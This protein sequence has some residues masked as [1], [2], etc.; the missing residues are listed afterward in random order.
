MLI[1]LVCPEGKNCNEDESYNNQGYYRKYSIMG[2]GI[3]RQYSGRFQCDEKCYYTG[4]N[5]KSALT[6][7]DYT[8]TII[9][10][11]DAINDKLKACST[12]SACEKEEKTTTFTISA[13]N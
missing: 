10:D 7:D 8:E 1:D 4:C 5:K 2:N 13:Q 3:K 11:L 12:T 6:S 9:N